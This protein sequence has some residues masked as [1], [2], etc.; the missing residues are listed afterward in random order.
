[1]EEKEIKKLLRRIDELEF[2]VSE[3]GTTSMESGGYAFT[4]GNVVDEVRGIFI[5]KTR[6]SLMLS[7]ATLSFLFFSCCL[8]SSY[9]VIIKL[10]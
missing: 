3:I 1:M 8:S 6:L 4:K 2:E 9:Y 10:P 7:Q 5:T